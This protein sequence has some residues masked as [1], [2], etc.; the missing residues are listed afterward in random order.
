M[1]RNISTSPSDV[2]MRDA[3]LLLIPVREDTVKKPLHFLTCVCIYTNTVS[4]FCQ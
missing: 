2:D 4:K 1:V 3:L